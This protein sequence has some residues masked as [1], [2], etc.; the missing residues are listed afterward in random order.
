MGMRKLWDSKQKLERINSQ[1]VQVDQRRV[2]RGK[3]EERHRRITI[4]LE[5]DLYDKLQERR[6]EG[7]SQTRV[8]N[9]ALR[10]F[11]KNELVK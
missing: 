10:C 11:W 6:I 4:Y 5:W 3:F 2:P 1:A 8:I 7:I 9:D